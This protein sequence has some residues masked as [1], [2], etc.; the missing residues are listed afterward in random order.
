MVELLT[1][2]HPNV[3]EEEKNQREGKLK[4]FSACA[5]LC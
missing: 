5:S 1:K 2:E 3:S 4:T